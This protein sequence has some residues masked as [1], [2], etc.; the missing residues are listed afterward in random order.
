MNGSRDG[1]RYDALRT[2]VAIVALAV[3]LLLFWRTRT[4]LLTVFLGV[5]FALAVSSG[6]DRLQRWKVPR[7]IA[8]PLI[9]FAFVGLVAAFGSWIGPT[10][11]QQT[12]ELRTKL[13]EALE[14]LEDWVQSR[15]GGVIAT[16]I[17]FGEEVTPPLPAIAGD[18]A[19]AAAADTLVVVARSDSA[20]GAVGV[21]APTTGKPAPA[22][23]RDRVL[24]QLG[25]AGRYF[26]H[27]LGSTLAVVSGIVLVIFLAIYLAIDPSVYRRGIVHLVPERAR[28]RTEETLTAIAVTLRKWLVTQLIAMLVIGAVT[29]VVLMV[30]KVR[31]AVPL[32]ILAGL[33]EFVPTLGP[34]LS[35]L[36]AI[37]MGFVDS[38]EK[39][40]AVAIAYVGIQFLENHL[41]I[42]ILMREGLDL[43]PALTIVMQA[44][45]AI[46]FG[47]LGLL[48]A[49]PLLAA[50]MIATRTL[51][52]HRTPAG[53]NSETKL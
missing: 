10:V 29:T 43:P 39:A 30:L 3:A 33:L 16:V 32:G 49:V 4:L 40:L 7:G 23:L 27:L 44:L 37:A 36:P 12:T 34:I 1:Q 14:K 28:P 2:A 50:I 18:S 47:V 25:G 13:P 52:R 26:L 41:L 19:A 9:V 35:S 24:G 51:T 15:G 53:A 21:V 11:R 6:V 8:A 42:P 46:V 45:M 5:L 38:P 20:K 48:V 17:G 22:S 31:A